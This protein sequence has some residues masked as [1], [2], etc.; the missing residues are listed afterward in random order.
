MSS[1]E[2]A[3]SIWP[4][5][6]GVDAILTRRL[7]RALR[8]GTGLDFL[9]PTRNELRLW[10]VSTPTP[11]RLTTAEELGHQR[12]VLLEPGT[13]VR[14]LKSEDR[15]NLTDE[16]WWI[17]L[18]VYCYV[19]PPDT[20]VFE[21]LDG[22]LR[23]E[24]VEINVK[25]PA[26]DW[27]PASLVPVWPAVRI[28]VAEPLDRKRNRLSR[29]D[30]WRLELRIIDYGSLVGHFGASAAP[31]ARLHVAAALYDQGVALCRLD[32]REDALVAW[33]DLLRRFGD[34][35]EPEIGEIV[36]AARAQ[37]Q[38]ATALAGQSRLRRLLGRWGR[39]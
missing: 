6:P 32:R 12:E 28:D 19:A 10:R 1:E 36:A 29:L 38:R 3:D 7:A 24:S 27:P 34:E 15:R 39:G 21:V 33:R 17:E 8:S 13:S 2:I 30:R 4:D 22:R 14:W 5:I 23:G 35:T 18:Q 16:E 26:D 31:E 11:A 37:I 25:E 20:H 9:C